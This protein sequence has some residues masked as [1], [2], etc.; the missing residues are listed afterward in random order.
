MPH[1]VAGPKPASQLSF[2]P[3]PSTLWDS[4][5]LF[6]INKRLYYN[7]KCAICFLTWQPK[8][9]VKSTPFPE[10]AIWFFQIYLSVVRRPEKYSVSTRAHGRNGF[11][12]TIDRKSTRLN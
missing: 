5:E 7:Q 1:L 10:E 12:K 9:V 6:S 11:E 3:Q 8:S 2:T 4:N